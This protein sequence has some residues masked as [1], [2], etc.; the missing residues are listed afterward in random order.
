MLLL[1]KSSITTLLKEYKEQ[2]MTTYSG[3]IGEEHLEIDT[4]SFDYGDSRKKW[5]F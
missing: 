1:T 4:A 5:D 2:D 3:S